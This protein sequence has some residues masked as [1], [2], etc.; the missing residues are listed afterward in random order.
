MLKHKFATVGAASMPMKTS[1]RR[2]HDRRSS[3][4]EAQT[5]AQELALSKALKPSKKFAVK[6]FSIVAEATG[7]KML[8]TSSSGSGA[9]H[10][11]KCVLNLF[12]SDL[13]PSD[14]EAV[15]VERSRKHSKETSL[16]Q[17]IPKSST[18][19]GIFE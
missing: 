6:T 17:D 5:S 14:G 8:C 16:A 10:A 15:P 13:L 12:G 19:R 1:G 3:H 11:A 4:S 18:L 9:A 7:K 2:G